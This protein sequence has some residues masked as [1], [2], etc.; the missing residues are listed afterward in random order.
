MEESIEVQEPQNTPDDVV[1]VSKAELDEIMKRAEASSQNFERLKKAEEELKALKPKLQEEKVNSF[2]SDAL[3]KE[4]DAKVDL[5]LAGHSQE[6]I[7][8]IEAYAKGK[9]LSLT[10]AA[11]SPFVKKAVDGIRAEKKSTENT[12]A[13]SSKIKVF[14]GKPVDEIFKSGTEAEKQSAFEARLRGGVKSNE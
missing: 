8:E 1:Q 3:R 13:P 6:E 4:I 2:D 14:N 7:A 12:P 11:Q 5:R 10:E 9:G